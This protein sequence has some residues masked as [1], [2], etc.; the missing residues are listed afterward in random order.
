MKKLLIILAI[1]TTATVNAQQAL[2]LYNMDMISQSNQVNPSMIPG[3]KFYIGIPALSG[4]R[5]MFTN[6]GF[7][8][9]DLHTV[10]TD[11]SVSLDVDNAISKLASRNF[12]SFSFRMNILEGG[13]T[14]KKNY[15]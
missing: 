8:W 9:R 2:T 15:F 12:I 1:A 4:T 14:M 10:R 13:F 6:C 7:T 11:D 3:N 5:I